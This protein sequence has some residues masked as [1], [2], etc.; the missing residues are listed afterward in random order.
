MRRVLRAIVERA[1]RRERGFYFRI[2]VDRPEIA[3]VTGLAFAT[4]GEDELLAVGRPA[5]EIRVPGFG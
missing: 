1:G 4:A 2:D 3:I 5:M